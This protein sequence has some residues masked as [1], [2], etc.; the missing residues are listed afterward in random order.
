MIIFK[1]IYSPEEIKLTAQIAVE[2]WN[3]S[4]V[5]MIG[6]DQTNYMLDKFDP[7]KIIEDLKSIMEY[8]QKIKN[9]IE[10]ILCEL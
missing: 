8:D 6:Q 2:I 3:D 9:I 7:R 10:K 5:D 4:F 1:K